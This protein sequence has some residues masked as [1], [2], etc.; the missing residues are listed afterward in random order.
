M[1]C[2]PQSV[3]D[4]QLTWDGGKYPLNHVVLG[5]ELLY[6]RPDHISSLKTPQ[7]VRDMAKALP[8]ITAADFRRRYFAI[9]AKS[10]GFPMSEEDL[11]YT[12]DWFQGIRELFA[13]AAAAGRYV[14]FSA[15]Q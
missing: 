13:R 14:L 4:G 5:G 15:S 2:P 6:T 10:Y 11:E 12:W 8:S 7:Q 9:D 1:G 3:A